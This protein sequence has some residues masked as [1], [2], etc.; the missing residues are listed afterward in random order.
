MAAS[1]AG[2]GFC[3]RGAAGRLIAVK[4]AK[5]S[6]ARAAPAVVTAAVVTAAAKAV[7]RGLA[8]AAAITAIYKLVYSYGSLYGPNT[9]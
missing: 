6:T 8:A 4:P 2:K 1:A 7:G 9:Y 3:N 5:L